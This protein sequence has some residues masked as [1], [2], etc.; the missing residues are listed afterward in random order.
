MPQGD[1][2]GPMGQGPRTGKSL[3][4]CSG[5]DTPGFTRGFEGQGRGF[6]F[7]Q[8]MGKGRG[9]GRGYRFRNFGKGKVQNFPNIYV[10]SKED[11]IN[12]LKLQAEYF[13][14]SQQVI[15]KRLEELEGKSE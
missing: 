15:E 5:Y 1:R 4:L 7:G 11:E 12:Q 14:S 9:F 3:G 8:N 13:K 6:G 2:T 10:M